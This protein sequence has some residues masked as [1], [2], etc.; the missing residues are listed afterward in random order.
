M[1]TISYVTLTSILL[2]DPGMMYRF[3]RFQ[4]CILANRL[5]LQLFTQLNSSQLKQKRRDSAMLQR[6]LSRLS[7]PVCLEGKDED[8]SPDEPF[9]EEEYDP[10]EEEVDL[11]IPPPPRAIADA[12]PDHP[13]TKKYSN[14]LAKHALQEHVLMELNVTLIRYSKSDARGKFLFLDQHICLLTKSG[15][16]QKTHLIKF[17]DI[18]QVL[19]NENQH[20][21][22][23]IVSKDDV[24]EL[25]CSF[26][27][28]S[29][30]CRINSLLQ[31]MSPSVGSLPAASSS[32]P[33]KRLDFEEDEWNL[34]LS[35]LTTMKVAR[36]HYLTKL[37]TTTQTVFQVISGSF[38]IRTNL[39]ATA[40]GLCPHAG[41]GA[42]FG[43]LTF[44]QGGISTADIIADTDDCEVICFEKPIIDE[45]T[46]TDPMLAGKFYRFLA[47]KMVHRFLELQLQLL[48]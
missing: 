41:P 10:S 12:P 46:H 17:S 22:V 8:S 4:C 2:S 27:S 25:H 24:E 18:R 36:G 32:D 48:S 31:T 42:V 14:L 39:S 35:R 38:I 43:D 34:L 11:Y 1:A 47:A 6:N 30:Y 29:D 26:D 37:A 15:F 19:E 13:L 7:D 9:S 45:L 23:I 28:H 21:L 16:S 40:S 20:M 33:F 3:F 44:I 5:V